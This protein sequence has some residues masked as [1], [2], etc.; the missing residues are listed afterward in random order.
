VSK[1]R[2]GGF[3]GRGSMPPFS[4]EVLSDDD[5]AGVLAWFALY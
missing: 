3:G 1:V 2:R 4:R 5:L